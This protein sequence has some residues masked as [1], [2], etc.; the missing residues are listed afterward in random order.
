MPKS[1]L[2]ALLALSLLSVVPTA[3]AQ[4]PHF[5]DCQIETGQ[6]ASLAVPAHANLIMVSAPSRHAA[7]GV[8]MGDEVAAFTPEGLC[9]GLLVWDG[10][11]TVLSLW[12]DDPTTPAKDGFAPGDEIGFR[13]WDRSV[14]REFVGF[15]VKYDGVPRVE[16]VASRDAVYVLKRIIAVPEE[17]S[18]QVAA[19]IA[20]KFGEG[21]QEE[22]APLVGASAS[23]PAEVVLEPGYP[24]PF[25]TSA[26]FRYGLPEATEVRLE[27]IDLS[28]RRVATLVD[29]TQAP[30]W[31]EADLSARDLAAGVYVVRL[32]AGDT[33]VLRRVTLVQ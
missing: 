20:A 4:T 25:H 18:A 33:Q 14:G 28:G 21:P 32:R 16:A 31:H 8:G 3:H 6:N 30:G 15:N 29:G 5:Q 22:E 19:A 26:R 7:V 24:N 17:F 12:I 2:L 11:S 10:T 1:M 23:Q 9:A 27:V 13:L